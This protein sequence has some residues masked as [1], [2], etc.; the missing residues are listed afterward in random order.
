M[1][2][3]VTGATGFVAGHL[4]PR[5]VDAGHQVI[6]A[7]H[8]L[9]RIDRRAGAVPLLWDLRRQEMPA[10]V[11]AQLD[12]IVHLAQANVPFPA[13]AAEMFAV[14]L[15]ATQRL[16]E[17]ARERGA[18]RFIF[19][20]SGSVYGAGDRP[21]REDAPLNGPGY[22]AATKIGAEKLVQAFGELVPYTIFRLFAPYGPGQSGRLVP[23]LINRVRTGQPVAVAGGTGP[24]F[25]PLFVTHICDVLEQALAAAGN[26]LLNL[27]GDE[28]LSVRD[29]AQII[30]RELGS[31]PVFQETPGTGPADIVGD[32]HELRR[33]YH[34]PPRLTDFA[35]GVRTML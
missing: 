18:R 3:L 17:V 16:L 21:W 24:R 26:Q 33:H 32:I 4:I 19:A 22:Y 15:A 2:V 12:A 23:G 28:A 20:S 13:G 35:G 1:N 34:L 6:A 7:G 5:L 11:P 10:G 8:D 29:M 25:N 27:G 30:G 31:E 14:H 9:T